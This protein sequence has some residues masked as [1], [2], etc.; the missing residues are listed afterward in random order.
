[1]YSLSM[2][3]ISQLILVITILLLFI[4]LRTMKKHQGDSIN[5]QTVWSY[6]DSP[7][8]PPI[9]KRCI[10]NWQ[11]VGG[12]RDIR[13]LNKNTISNWIPQ[14]E[15]NYFT[16]ITSNEA[17]KSDLI[18]FYLLKNYGG[19][20]IDASVF[21]N[22]NAFSW[23]PQDNKVFCFKADRFSKEEI[24]C[25]ENFFIKSPKND[26][27]IVDWFNQCIEDFTDTKYKENNKKYRDI[28]GKNGDY[29][30]PYVSSMKLNLYK[31]P[32]LITQSAEKG[33]YKDTIEHNWDADKIC[34]NITYTEN[35]VKLYNQ[36]RDK[37]SEDIIP[38]QPKELVTPRVIVQTYHV[39]S[40]I[41]SYVYE[42][43]KK[44]APDYKHIIYDDAEAYTFI[45][46]HFG[47]DT[48]SK[49]LALRQGPHK[50]DLFRYCYLYQY[51]GIYLDIKTELIKPVTEIFTNDYLY[52][53]LSIMNN[54]IYNGIIA[55]PPKDPVFLDLIQFMVKQDNN[56]HYLYN[57]VEM[58][59]ML[60]KR[61]G[62]K[63]Q[64]GYNPG[65]TYLFEEVCTERDSLQRHGD[66]SNKYKYKY[67][68]Q[69]KNGT[70]KYGL[71][72]YIYDKGDYIIKGRY[73]DFPWK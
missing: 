41:P 57:C 9:I 36:T 54:S 50:A 17:N 63:L 52:S 60:K 8:Q 59:N 19:I 49:F 30:V 68:T 18:R 71:C 5:S 2:K 56:P 21:F 15:L 37:C 3:D 26:P 66:K 35:L 7:Y 64:Q 27:F 23:L 25:L 67:H 61:S 10:E 14:S 24:T 51:G 65:N 53:V 40:K 46:K 16:K 44:Y 48:A 34:K 20:W 12:F 22:K 33:P 39:K 45:E 42:N 32:N 55:T 72:C 73:S 70:D 29:L 28:I 11:S 6:W 4:V 38:L 47:I 43:I 31:Y 1:M 13:V 62:S 69:C 58:Y